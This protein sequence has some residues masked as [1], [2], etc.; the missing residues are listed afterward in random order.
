MSELEQQLGDNVTVRRLSDLYPDFNID[1]ATEQQALVDADVVVLQFPIFWYNVPAILKKWLDDVWTY[2]FAY[3]EGGDKLHG[4]KLFVSLTTGGVGEVYTDEVMS[5]MD[6]L[7]RPIK[8]SAKYAGFEWAGFEATYAQLY[9]PGVHSEAD[10]ANVQAKA[11][12]HA[13]RVV[14]KLKAL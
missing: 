7:L 14:A 6:D 10:L 4:K 3:G 1:V 13:A 8:C 11:K 9:I 12:D 2:G 5:N